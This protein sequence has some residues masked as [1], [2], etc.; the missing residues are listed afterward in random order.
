MMILEKN[1][2]FRKLKN[3]QK[4]LSHNQDLKKRKVFAYIM[5][6]KINILHVNLILN[7]QNATP[8]TKSSRRTRSVAENADIVFCTRSAAESVSISI[9]LTRCNISVSVMVY[10]A[11]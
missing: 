5:H 6:L 1:I 2:T 4:L 11:R 9:F 3:C 8:R 10:D 7:V